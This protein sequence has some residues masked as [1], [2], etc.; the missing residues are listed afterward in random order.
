MADLLP[1]QVERSHKA[2]TE[3]LG[4]KIDVPKERQFI[5]FDAYRKAIDCLRP[6]DVAMLTTH[7][8]FRAVHLNYAVEKGVNVFMEKDFAADPG[9]VQQILR[10]GEAAEK[11]NLKI[12]A[13][14]MARHSSAR[15]AMIQ[16]I[17]DGA[18]GDIQLIRA[19]RMDSGYRMD[20]FQ[21]NE[22]ELLWQL[23]P[24]HPYQFLWSSGGIFIELMIH[25]IDECF[26]I[27][28]AWPVSAHGVGG[29][30]AGSTDCSQNLDSYSIEYTFADGT[31]ALVTGRYIP[32]CFN[33]F[34]TYVHGTKC[35][36]Q[37][38]GNIHA[39]SSQ[40]YK[41]QR[42]AA[43][44]VAWKPAKETVNPW[45]AEWHVLLDAIRNDRPHNEA[46]RAALSNL[47]AIMGRAAVHT[48]QI[49][50]WDRRH[51]LE[52][53]VLPERRGSD[54]GQPGTGPS[55]RARPLSRTGPRRVDG[56]L[57]PAQRRGGFGDRV[58]IS[59]RRGEADPN[60]RFTRLHGCDPAQFDLAL[61]AKYH[62][63]PDKIPLSR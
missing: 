52:V 32:N 15:Q 35:A 39:P 7:A 40:I 16:Q 60:R 57:I 19:Y 59:K 4:D 22:N 63:R 49:V 54:G 55:R 61:V 31:K 37:F 30:I 48:G 26:W 10:A 2:L 47:G 14:L 46:R 29:R 11:K 18:M 17:R 23:R 38:S 24:G 25:Q 45:Q 9:G 12:A 13:G 62:R 28:D 3:L 34:V 58:W 20:P 5:G 53:R 33:D 8:G 51:G 44:N 50:T 42:I 36:G 56:D 21:R 27:K 43:D 1:E 41:D 6:G